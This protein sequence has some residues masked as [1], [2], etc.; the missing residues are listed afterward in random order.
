[1]IVVNSNAVSQLNVS[2]APTT[3]RHTRNG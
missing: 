2:G 3:K 1:M